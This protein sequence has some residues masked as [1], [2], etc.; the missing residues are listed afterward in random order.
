MGNLFNT[1]SGY[2]ELLE[3]RHRCV[4][5]NAHYKPSF[6][7][8]SERRSCRVHQLENGECKYCHDKVGQVRGNC[9]HYK[10]KTC[11]D[12]LGF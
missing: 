6:G 10:K 2:Y 3:L 5:C 9:Y 8:Y 1:Q 4:K 11:W 12:L 7:T